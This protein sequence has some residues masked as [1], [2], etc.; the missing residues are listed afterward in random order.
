M[1]LMEPILACIAQGKF[2]ARSTCQRQQNFFFIFD[3]FGNLFVAFGMG[4]HLVMIGVL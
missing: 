4:F 3:F 2:S 1:D